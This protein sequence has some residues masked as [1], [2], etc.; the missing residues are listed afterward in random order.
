[1]YLI[2]FQIYVDKDPQ[3]KEEALEQIKDFL[4]ESKCP[5]EFVRWKESTE[6]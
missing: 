1:M 2:Q 4:A 6:I 5:E 3:T